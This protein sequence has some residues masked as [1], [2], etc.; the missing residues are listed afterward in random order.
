MRK[1]ITKGLT[2]L[3]VIAV[4]VLTAGCSGESRHEWA[5]DIME[6]DVT[7]ETLTIPE[8]TLPYTLDTGE[9]GEISTQVTFNYPEVWQLSN[10][11]EDLGVESKSEML[12]SFVSANGEGVIVER[13]TQE[14]EEVREVAMDANSSTDTQLPVLPNSQL[15]GTTSTEGVKI[16]SHKV[17][18]TEDIE[19][20]SRIIESADGYSY[21]ITLLQRYPSEITDEQAKYIMDS[22]S[23][24]G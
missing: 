24:S 16:V 20:V 12:T 8:G 1:I 9:D 2:V 7:S 13:F 3:P 15:T 17:A 18:G 19:Q 10:S 23:L 14:L 21:S 4:M 22:F 5:V 6:P 11:R